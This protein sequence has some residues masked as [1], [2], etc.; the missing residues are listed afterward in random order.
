MQQ[1][2]ND[3]RD[4]LG[5]GPDDLR[6][7]RLPRLCGGGVRGRVAVLGAAPEVHHFPPVAV[8]GDRRAPLAAPRKVVH[9]CVPDRL[10]AVLDR[11]LDVHH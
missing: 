3:R 8:D 2:R 11:A 7:P 6:R 10:E 5:G 1:Q 4:A 9:E